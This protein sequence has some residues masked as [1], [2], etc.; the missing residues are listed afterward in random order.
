MKLTNKQKVFCE[1]C[2]IDLNATQAAIRAGYSEK[3]ARQMG[4]E[5]LS[6]PV[7]QKYIQ[8]QMEQRAE[9]LQISADDVLREIKSVA[10]SEVEIKGADKMKALDLLG[11]HL[12]LWD[13]D[14]EKNPRVQIVLEGRDL[15]T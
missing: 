13:K 9:R 10:E 1:E 4:A 6:K 15:L 3:T 14:E 12:N 7:I 5:N 8:E 2:Q 11:R